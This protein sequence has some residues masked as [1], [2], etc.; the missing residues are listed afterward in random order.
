[1]SIDNL[2][3]R[4]CL[5]VYP[6][7]EIC[8]EKEIKKVRVKTR[9]HIIPRVAIS[10]HRRLFRPLQQS[11]EN[12]VGICQYHHDIIDSHKTGAYA[13]KG[14]AGVVGFVAAYPRADN[15]QLLEWQYNKW[16]AIF[17]IVKGSLAEFSEQSHSSA[18]RYREAAKIAKRFWSRWREGGI[19]EFIRTGTP[20]LKD[21]SGMPVWFNSDRSLLMPVD[22]E[23]IA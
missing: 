11:R 23:A 3:V 14:L 7:V 18:Y 17:G 6:Q 19:D 16:L 5:F 12:V 1:M 15:E 20:E 10:D 13:K 8:D 2:H 4:D 21:R 9:D 22:F